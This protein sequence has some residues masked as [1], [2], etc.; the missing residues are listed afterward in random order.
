VD[1][2]SRIGL[3][4][5]RATGF[6]RRRRQESQEE[7]RMPLPSLVPRSVLFGAPA[8]VFP[9]LSP[10]GARVA[11]IGPVDGV[12]NIWLQTVG[13]PGARPVTSDAAGVNAFDWAADGRE[14]ELS[15]GNGVYDLVLLDLGLPKRDGIDVLNGYR[16]AGGDAAVTESR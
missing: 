13:K 8:R 7:D 1:T 10:D 12:P 3:N 14:A 15:L 4:Y 9:A 16:K 2:D 5:R 6:G 11:Y